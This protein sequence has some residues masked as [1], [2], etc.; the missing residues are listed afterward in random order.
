MRS[1]LAA[2]LLCTLAATGLAQTAPQ[3]PLPAVKLTAGMHLITAELA[4][5]DRERMVGLMFRDKLAPNHGMLFDFKGKSVHC[6]WMRNT[7]IPLSVA[8]LDDD[9][10]IVNIEDMAPKTED[11]HCAKKPV[12]FAL[13]MDRGWFAQRGIKP[14]MKL[15]GLPTK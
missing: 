11:S 9:G 2:L 10:T 4:D 15:G 6:M 8:Y 1:L 12:R 14:G 13:E 5:D 7:L 3:P